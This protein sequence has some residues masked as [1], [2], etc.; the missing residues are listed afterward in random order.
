[1]SIISPRQLRF[2]P[3]W[4]EGLENLWGIGRCR[5]VPYEWIKK[6]LKEVHGVT[7]RADPKE[8]LLAADSPWGT[9]PPGSSS[10]EGI[11]GQH[12]SGTQGKTLSTQE[13]GSQKSPGGRIKDGQLYVPLEEIYTYDETG[14]FV[15]RFIIKIGKKIFLD[16]AFGGKKIVCPLQVCRHTDTGRAFSR[17]FV[18]PLIPFN[19]Q[20]EK[21][22]ASFFRNITELDLFG[23]LF[24]PGSSGINLENWRTGPRPR[25]VKYESDLM[26]PRERPFVLQP[27][28]TGKMPAQFFE[29]TAGIADELSGQGP[30]FRGQAAGRVDS[31]AGEGFLFNIANIGLG[32]PSH[33]LADGIAGI[34]AR[35][36]QAAQE[37]LDTKSFLE[38]A[39]VDDAIA[40]VVLDPKT[41]TMQLDNNAIP[42]PWKVRIDIIDRT[43]RDKDVRK[44]ELFS[45]YQAQL[46]DWTRYWLTVYQENLDVPG[47]PKDIW[48]TWRKAVWQIIILFGDGQ[49]FGK[50]SLKPDTQ[51]PDVQLMAVQQFMNKIEFSLASEPVQLEFEKW[52]EQLEILAGQAFPVGL[53]APEDLAAQQRALQGQQPQ[54]GSGGVP[55]V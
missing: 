6:R 30:M 27:A 24:V 38:I 28:N 32:L 12:S 52:K 33:G 22:L 45:L 36:L 16:R 3:A 19:D 35:M 34:Y 41:G 40:G 26:F 8:D 54:G 55:Q 4:V 46:V 5:W 53:G 29:I 11:S 10:F 21:M 2:Y 25:A 43:L 23:T 48:E 44:Q 31:A 42:D 1:M 51:N 39:V 20:S 13:R 18:S 47:G 50:I 17:G 7:M 37:R 14:Y 15:D 49:T 9:S